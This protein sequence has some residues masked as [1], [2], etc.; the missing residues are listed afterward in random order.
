MI[1]EQLCIYYQEKINKKNFSPKLTQHIQIIFIAQIT[2]DMSSNSIST[3]RIASYPH[4]ESSIPKTISFHLRCP[5]IWFLTRDS[6]LSHI[7]RAQSP[8]LHPFIWGANHKLQVVLLVLLTNELQT[9]FQTTV[10]V[11]LI[12]SG[13]YRTQESIYL[14]LVVYYKG[15]YK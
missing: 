5:L 3:W 11:W 6:I 7:L 2:S 1:M 4:T 8:K 9:R 12:C 13:C 14:H 15:H 10:W